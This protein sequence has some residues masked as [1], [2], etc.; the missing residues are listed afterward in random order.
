MK[1]L[2]TLA[3]TIALFALPQITLAKSKY[4]LAEDYFSIGKNHQAMQVLENIILA[5]PT[6]AEVHLQV[7]KVYG[8]H[9]KW[10]DFDLAMKNACS[11]DFAKCDDVAQ[12]Y[13]AIAFN[14]I[15]ARGRSRRSSRAFDKAFEYG[16]PAQKQEA[17]TRIYEYG[18]QY[19]NAGHYQKG[20]EFFLVLCG[21]DNSYVTELATLF[22]DTG[23]KANSPEATMLLFEYASEYSVAN[24]KEMGNHLANM[25]KE[26]KY[27][28]DMKNKLKIEAGKYLSKDEMLKYYPLDYK[29]YQHGTY[30]FK[31]KAGETTE[32]WI[33]IADG[34]RY[35]L[36]APKDKFQIIFRNNEKVPSW[37]P[38][39]WPS[40]KGHFKI[41]S[42]VDDTITLIVI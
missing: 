21:Y 33:D 37:S 15:E 5:S 11:L 25:S 24:K 27:S 41:N 42:L 29:T 17:L 35:G 16:T 19:F 22:F 36:S 23:I 14:L 3:L 32:L 28:Q 30:S 12:I 1:K 10:R 38:G 31:M 39:N 40:N 18:M 7:G 6:N 34:H 26:D 4:K 20:K 9:N 2:L 8:R 13:Y